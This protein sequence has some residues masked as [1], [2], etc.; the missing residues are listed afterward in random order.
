MKRTFAY[1]ALAVIVLNSCSK[2]ASTGLNDAAKRY[3]DA[4]MSV[5]HPDLKPTELGAYVVSET[6]G[7][8][9]YVGTQDESPYLYVN[10]ISRELNGKINDFT[11]EKIAK[12]LGT[13]TSGTYYGPQIW[14]RSDDNLNA[15]LDEMVTTMREGGEKTTIIPGWLFSFDRYDDAQGYLDN[16]TGTNLIYTVEVLERI[17]D[18]RSWEIDS[19]GRY[20]SR[21]YPDVKREDSLKLGFYYKCLREPV[22]TTSYPNDTTVYINYVG[23][24]LNG[25]VFDTNIA[26]TAKFYGIYSSSTTYGPSTI[27][28]NKDDYTQIQ[29]GSSSVIDGFGYCL[30]H[31]RRL[32]KGSCIFMS[33]FG[34]STSGSGSNIPG[35][36]PLRF[37]IEIVNKDE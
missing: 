14:K 26:D 15:G 18:M 16:V 31:M 24:L 27:T 12:Q 10:Y 13:Y 35:Y 17:I 30:H 29:M 3:F 7:D 8:G 21:V 28:W 25:T 36:S 34:Y 19:I 9:K 32:E 22:D 1:L 33:D 6:K 2:A 23:R 11:S 20:L 37:D 5:N 4:W